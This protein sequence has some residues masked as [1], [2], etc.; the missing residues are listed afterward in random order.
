M[1]AH[2]LT[3]SFLLA[4]ALGGCADSEP[5]TPATSGADAPFVDLPARQATVSGQVL[6]P[7][8]F[9]V[10]YQAY[11]AMGPAFLLDGIPYLTYSAIPGARVRLYGPGLPDSLSPAS[12]PSGEWQMQGVA[13]SS[14]TPYLAQALPPDGP[15]T[16]YT[17]EYAAFVMPPATYY[18]TTYLRP[19]Q[20]SGTQCSS[21]QALMVGSAGALDAVARHLT[22]RGTPTTVEDLLNPVRTGGVVLFWVQVPNS[23]FD[24][25]WTPLD[26]VAGEASAGTLMALDWAM[27]EELPGQSPLG[28]SVLPDPVSQVGYFALVL[29]PGTVAPVTVRFTDTYVSSP[30]EGAGPYGT[31]PLPIPPVVV[32]P[33][34]GVSV[35]R[36][37][38]LFNFTVDPP[39][40]LDDPPPPP[41]D[42]SWHCAPPPPPE[43]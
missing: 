26:S 23:Y 19:I 25:E 10:H 36:V 18:P 2:S 38:S 35:Q 40:P 34:P 9:F 14:Q 5:M 30:E 41:F 37:F 4:A 21:Q 13:P 33:R 43:G 16:F 20:V 1:K 3:A 6:D 42:S 8:A 39:D 12:S 22:A 28:F 32:Q 17:D 29:P 7:E 11:G 27:P 31:R 15:V 24:F